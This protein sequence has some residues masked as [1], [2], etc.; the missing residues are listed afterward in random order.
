MRQQVPLVPMLR[1]V[2]LGVPEAGWRRNHFVIGTT[3]DPAIVN[4]WVILF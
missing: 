2:R 4:S 1:S 3:R